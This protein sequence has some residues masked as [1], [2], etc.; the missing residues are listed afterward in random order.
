MGGEKAPDSTCPGRVWGSPP[1]GR[2]KDKKGSKNH[3]TPRITP[4]WA[5]KSRRK[6]CLNKECED[7]PRMGGEKFIDI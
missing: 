4:A 7:H 6:H 3:P 1:H 2:G 5:G